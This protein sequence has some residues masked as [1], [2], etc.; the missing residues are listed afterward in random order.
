MPVRPRR[1][2]P[3]P[4]AV[5]VARVAGPAVAAGA[6]ISTVAV[7]AWPSSIGSLRP[8]RS[9][10]RRRC[11]RRSRA[12]SPS[13]A[14]AG[15][16]SKADRGTRSE[17]RPALTAADGRPPWWS[18]ASSTPPRTSP[19]RRKAAKKK[20][21]ERGRRPPSYDERDRLPLHDGRLKLR[22]TASKDAKSVDIVDRPR[23]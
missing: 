22:K 19:P 8:C 11:C 15:R 20:A 5:R 23:S 4:I 18:G 3:A 7:T 21:A 16:A 10:L 17:T 1:A 12:P 6:L 14:E 9:I 2:M 13:A